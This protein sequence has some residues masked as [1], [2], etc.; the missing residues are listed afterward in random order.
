MLRVGE[1]SDIRQGERS[2][3]NLDYGTLQ[4]LENFMGHLLEQFNKRK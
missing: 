3:E 1:E 2:L 4:I